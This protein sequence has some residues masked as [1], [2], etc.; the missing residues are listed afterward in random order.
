[1]ILIAIIM[2]NSS[3]LT[4]RIDKDREPLID[5]G[6]PLVGHFRNK[7]TVK[8]VL[9]TALFLTGILGILLFSPGENGK[10]IIQLD[11]TIAN[12]GILGFAL[13]TANILAVSSIDTAV[14]YHLANKEIIDLN[15]IDWKF[16]PTGKNT[17]IKA[18]NDFRDKKYQMMEEEAENKRLEQYREEIELYRK[19]LLDRTIT[20]DELSLIKRAT[21]F[22]EELKDEVSYYYISKSKDI[23]TDPN[24][25]DKEKIEYYK[26]KL[27]DGT[28]SEVEIENIEKDSKLKD[29]LKNELGFYYVNKSI[30]KD[31]K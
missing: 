13:G 28:I 30:K 15:Q 25:I 27:I 31:K 4:I 24:E 29:T 18:I 14:T 16:D 21:K 20:E 12:Y 7:D 19:K 17:K 2:I 9:Y 5:Y 8:A 11:N 23:P 1:M 22:Q 26:Q 10:S 3:C 6:T